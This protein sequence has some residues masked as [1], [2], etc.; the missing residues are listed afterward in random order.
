MRSQ[1]VLDL[2]VYQVFIKS[3]AQ[4]AYA[5]ELA[6][7]YG[8]WEKT[9]TLLR[10]IKSVADKHGVM[11]QTVALRWQIDQVRRWRELLRTL[12]NHQVCGGQARGHDADSGAA[13]ADRP[14]AQ[15]EGIVKNS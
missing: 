5:L 7:N 8:G 2:R 11:M 6:N 13:M 10:T 12:R 9:Q 1:L 14:G 15:M 4:V 3:P